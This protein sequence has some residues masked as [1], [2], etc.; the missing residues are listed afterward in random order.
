MNRFYIDWKKGLEMIRHK[1]ASVEIAAMLVVSIFCCTAAGNYPKSWPWEQETVSDNAGDLNTFI[2]SESVSAAADAVSAAAD[3]NAEETSNQGDGVS[4]ADV[5]QAVAETAPSE[6]APPEKETPL[7]EAERME[8]APP[9]P[10]RL[11]KAYEFAS[12]VSGDTSE[13]YAGKAYYNLIARDGQWVSQMYSNRKTAPGIL[14]VSL[15]LT[16]RNIGNYPNW[17]NVNMLFYDGDGSMISGYSNAR[18]ILAMA[19]VYSYFHPFGS[20]EEFYEYTEQLWKA[21]HKYAV[22]ASDVYFCEGEC[23]YD[24]LNRNEDDSDAAWAD[25]EGIAPAAEPSAEETEAEDGSSSAAGNNGPLGPLKPAAQTSSNTADTETQP[26]GATAAE[27]AA[28]TIAAETTVNENNEN[29]GQADAVAETPAETSASARSLEP[30]GVS[31]DMAGTE[32]TEDAWADT[33]ASRAASGT[34]ETAEQ[35]ISETTQA[36]ETAAEQ[37]DSETAPETAPE[38]AAPE[39]ANSSA[40]AGPLGPLGQLSVTEPSEEASTGTAP[41]SEETLPAAANAEA[42]AELSPSGTSDSASGTL[43]AAG[44]GE[45]SGDTSETKCKGHVD[46]TIRATI[47]GLKENR[48][49]LYHADVNSDSEEDYTDSW[50]GWTM[51]RKRCVQNLL[52]QDW[53]ELYGLTAPSSM[54]IQ[55]PLTAAEIQYYMDMMPEDTSEDRKVLIKQALQSVGCIPYYWGGKPSGPGY[56]LNGFGT[57]TAPDNTGR[58][59]RGLDCS[60]WTWLYWTALGRHLP[61]ESTEGLYAIGRQIDRSELKPGDCIVRTGDDG[62]VCLFLAWAPDGTMYVIHERGSSSN[63]VIVSNYDLYWPYYRNLLD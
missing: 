29:V 33:N 45:S 47:I 13:S 3:D 7:T 4:A 34:A 18:E 14:A 30:L 35:N 46:L 61:Y 40:S 6:A 43:S 12:G 26:E 8:Q 31:P 23:K 56:E 22:S 55:N 62:H 1:K 57:L 32:T 42:G 28:E 58:C 53:F 39:A 20:A 19:S 10:S 27:G 51:L 50:K 54:Y 21:S 60:G 44:V 49:N 41:A 48:N 5:V 36:A 9:S 25:P 16:G 17:T 37:N 59:L 24:N 38:T 15:G 63:N 2:P 52:D 11:N